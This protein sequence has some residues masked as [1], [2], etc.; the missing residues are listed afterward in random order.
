MQPRPSIASLDEVLL[1]ALVQNEQVTSASDLRHFCL[2]QRLAW[3]SYNTCKTFDP[4]IAPAFGPT[5]WW[6]DPF[7]RGIHGNSEVSR[8]LSS[9]R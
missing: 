4:G 6:K 7:K 2:S 1:H 9:L 8:N 3:K 5:Y